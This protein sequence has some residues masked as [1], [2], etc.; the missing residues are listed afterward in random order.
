MG[1]LTDLKQNLK[2]GIEST[3]QRSKKL[4]DISRLTI[5]IKG[6]KEEEER[7][8]RQLGFEAYH[9]WE[10]KEKWEITDSLRA[11]LSQIRSIR[12]TIQRWEQ[13]LEELKKQEA[14][15]R[16]E[17]KSSEGGPGAPA[18]DTSPSQSAPL[19]SEGI[20][21]EVLAELEGQALFI[22]PHCTEQ[23]KED[24]VICPH[25]NKHMYH[26]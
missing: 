1:L 25:C 11:S 23:V 6:K 12:E 13:E 5:A 21:P 17:K 15:E 14:K 22:C 2:K 19:Q 26:D 10:R 16:L 4:V 8:Y 7:L 9:L 20:S 24:A 3:S 18:V